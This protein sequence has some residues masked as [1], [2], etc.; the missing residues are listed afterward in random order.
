MPVAETLE[1][2]GHLRALGLPLGHVIV[3]RLHRRH[4]D[5]AVLE[6]LR[7]AAERAPMPERALLACIAERAAEETGWS[8]I[9][10]AYVA[11]LRSGIGDVPLIE[12]PFLFVEEF[13]RTE[14]ELLSR[15]VEAGMAGRAE[16]AGRRRSRSS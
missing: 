11:R 9:N 12:L 1:S 6:R 3:N 4:F 2:C 5:P 14:L 16:A 15:L 10:A 13:G 8:D 7:A